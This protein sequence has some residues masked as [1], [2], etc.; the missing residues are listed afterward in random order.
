MA[1]HRERRMRL[2]LQCRRASDSSRVVPDRPAGISLPI[3]YA[4]ASPLRNSTLTSS[5]CAFHALSS[6]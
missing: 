5:S 1:M 2:P 4:V 6:L 3:S